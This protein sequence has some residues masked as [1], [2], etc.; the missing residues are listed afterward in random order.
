[1]DSQIAKRTHTYNSRLAQE[2]RKWADAQPG[3]EAVHGVLYRAYFIDNITVGEVEEMLMIVA[4]LDLGV[5]GAQSYE[6]L[7]RLVLYADTK[8]R[9]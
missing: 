9:D 5:W 3:G 1:M 8:P 2:L 4:A 7:E 6:L